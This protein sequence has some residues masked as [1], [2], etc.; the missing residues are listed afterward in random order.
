M[1]SNAERRAI[2]TG[3]SAVQARVADLYAA[4][5]GLVGKLELVYEGEQ[6]GTEAVARR[7]L[8]DAIRKC[9]DDR[10]PLVYPVDRTHRR[11]R[12]SPEDAPPS[13]ADAAY[14]PIIG[15]FAEGNS[16]DLSD[17][18]S[19]VDHRRE[20]DRVAGLLPLVRDHGDPESPDEE[21]LLMELALEGLHQHS[22]IARDELDGGV[23]FKDMLKDM[24]SG[25]GE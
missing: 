19:A 17:T 13:P 5:P 8:G 6:Q 7:V 1:V 22:V 21:T 16:V 12:R 9:F 24:L 11:R 25:M 18:S 20:L 14:R 23:S 10:F 4:V 15:W 3:E 2:A